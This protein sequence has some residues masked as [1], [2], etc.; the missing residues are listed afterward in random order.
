VFDYTKALPFLL[1]SLLRCTLLGWLAFAPVTAGEVESSGFGA[2]A[3]PQPDKPDNASAC[4][5][6]V[7]V[8]RREHMNFLLHQRDETVLDGERDGK[9]SLVGCMDCHNPADS[10]ETAIRYP[11]PQHFCAGCH[12]YTSVQIDCFECHADRGLGNIQQG[13]LAGQLNISSAAQPGLDLLS[14]QTF[15]VHRENASVD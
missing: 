1:T 13:E 3:I 8:M 9:Y 4:V 2:I 7:E 15:Q 5:E 11:D 10:A 12:L 6:P 14:L